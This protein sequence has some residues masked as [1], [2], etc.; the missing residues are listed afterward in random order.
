MF[1]YF[2]L[3]RY[4]HVPIYR[5]TQSMPFSVTDFC[6]PLSPHPPTTLGRYCRLFISFGC[7]WQNFDFV[8]YAS[9][10]RLEIKKKSNDDAEK[11]AHEKRTNWKYGHSRWSAVSSIGFSKERKIRRKDDSLLSALARERLLNC[12]TLLCRRH[13]VCFVVS[14]VVFRFVWITGIGALLAI[15]TKKNEEFESL[16]SRV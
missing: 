4:V 5:Q 13:D 15:P 9:P 11:D 16:V 2:T 8:S 14:Y 3:L 1:R 12:V 7:F 10:Y 6:I